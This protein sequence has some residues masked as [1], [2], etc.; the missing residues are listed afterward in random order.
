[1]PTLIFFEDR[2]SLPS[3]VLTIKVRTKKGLKAVFWGYITWL[4]RSMQNKAEGL[5]RSSNGSG[6][7]CLEID[8]TTMQERGLRR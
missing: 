1:M 8:H 5:R 2:T 4:F 3:T 6:F 7:S